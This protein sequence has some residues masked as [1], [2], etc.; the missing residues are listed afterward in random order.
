MHQNHNRTNNARP[1]EQAVEIAQACS[2]FQG[3]FYWASWL[4]EA[5]F[6][7]ACLKIDAVLDALSA[8]GF[9]A[10]ARQARAR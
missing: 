4:D 3:I 8:A 6:R 1:P 5:G 7:A 10:A 9:L 2:G